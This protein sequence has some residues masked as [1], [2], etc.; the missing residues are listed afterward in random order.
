MKPSPPIRF[1]LEIQTWI[2]GASTWARPMTST[3]KKLTMQLHHRQVRLRKRCSIRTNASQTWSKSCSR[4]KSNRRLINRML[5][6]SLKIWNATFR[7][8]TM[9]RKQRWTTSRTTSKHRF[10]KPPIG[11]RTPCSQHSWSSRCFFFRKPTNDID[12]TQ[13]SQHQM[14]ANREPSWTTL[15]QKWRTI[16]EDPKE[17]RIRPFVP[18]I[19]SN[20]IKIRQKGHPCMLSVQKTG[21]TPNSE[22][23]LSQSNQ[24]VQVQWEPNAKRLQK[25]EKLP[26]E[27]TKRQKVQRL[28]D[29]G[30]GQAR[31]FQSRCMSRPLNEQ[32][33][34]KVLRSHS[35]SLQRCPKGACSCAP[36][37][38]SCLLTMKQLQLHT[39]RFVY[40][41]RRKA[42]GYPKP[43]RGVLVPD[44][45]I[46][47]GLQES[48]ELKGQNLKAH[49]PAHNFVRMKGLRWN[50][51]EANVKQKESCLCSSRRGNK[52]RITWLFALL[53]YQ[54]HILRHGQRRIS[55]VK[56]K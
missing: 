6:G 52:M 20:K 27:V 45:Q 50:A 11:N 8:T 31:L 28:F 18:Q 16:C 34:T 13:T 25:C 35:E 24:P 36:T 42:D 17:A 48:H 9:P 40:R 32:R 51:R 4:L 41:C 47:L 39:C 55:L 12:Q 46:V 21:R 44:P 19:H 38:L 23:P 1:A 7:T 3:N 56:K 49:H 29:G 54:A 10:G 2:H 5:M 26:S 43:V 30:P 14:K 33:S 53:L 37:L 15:V 22:T